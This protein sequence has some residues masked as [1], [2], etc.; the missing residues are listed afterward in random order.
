MSTLFTILQ[1]VL[2]TAL[3]GLT[4]WR[5]SH[6]TEAETFVVRRYHL[7]TISLAALGVAACVHAHPF[8]IILPTLLLAAYGV[9]RYAIR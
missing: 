6:M 2:C 3:L 5:L 8:F 4:I 9:S 7:G 1:A